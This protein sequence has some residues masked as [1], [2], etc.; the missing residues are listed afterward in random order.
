MSTIRRKVLHVIDSLDLGGA[1]TL[2]LDICKHT[3]RGRFDVEVACMHG[4]GV[5]AEEFEKAGIRVHSL[6]PWKWPPGYI[7]GFLK[8]LKRWDPELRLARIAVSL[9][10]PRPLPR[11]S[12]PLPLRL[13]CPLPWTS[14]V[15]PRRLRRVFSSSW[16]PSSHRTS[17]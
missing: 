11:C 16:P 17:P 6:S 8:L 13:Y 10:E 2:L 5:F 15:I 7:P 14:L 9:A 12:D 4:R 1:Q 3:D